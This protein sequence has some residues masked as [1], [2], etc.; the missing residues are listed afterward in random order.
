MKRYLKSEDR[1]CI[2]DKKGMGRKLFRNHKSQGLS[3]N[4]IIVAVIV[5]VVLIV[6]WA[7]FTGKIGGFAQDLEKCRDPCELES[8]C[9]AV[10][11][12]ECDTNSETVGTATWYSTDKTVCC[13]IRENE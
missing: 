12:G 3:L 4:V 6:L 5:L 10:S 1:N 2:M 7:I 8:K 13:A 11:G 9:M